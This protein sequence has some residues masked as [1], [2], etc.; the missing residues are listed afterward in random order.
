MARKRFTSDALFSNRCLSYSVVKED[1]ELIV[2]QRRCCAAQRIDSKLDV[3]E[4]WVGRLV[5]VESR[6]CWRISRPGQQATAREKRAGAWTMANL[7]ADRKVV[8][9]TPR[10]QLSEH[11][12]KCIPSAPPLRGTGNR[13][14][15]LARPSTAP[16][17]PVEPRAVATRHQSNSRILAHPSPSLPRTT[18]RDDSSHPRQSIATSAMSLAGRRALSALSRPRLYVPALAGSPAA[19]RRLLS[20]L[21]VLEQKDGKLNVGSL[22]A[23]T[24]AQKLGGPVHAFVAGSNI[25]GVAE[26]AAKVEGVE[27][28]IAVEN[29][30]Y[31][32]VGPLFPCGLCLRYGLGLK[33]YSRITGPSRELCAALGREH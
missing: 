29:G 4:R 26:E 25:K 22:S 9:V 24:A 28:I 5:V 16:P 11:R 31:D 32:K 6:V 17:W 14:W 12:H 13:Q 15:T 8:H 33:S 10:P 21:A 23:V 18:P 3:A 19:L 27:K 20:A 2:V 30:A 7:R 1:R